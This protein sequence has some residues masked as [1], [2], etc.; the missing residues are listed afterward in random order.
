VSQQHPDNEDL[1]AMKAAYGHKDNTS[2]SGVSS[3]T[4]AANN[5]TTPSRWGTLTSSSADGKTQIYK[6]DLGDGSQLITTAYKK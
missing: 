4:N 3:N 1:T 2:S 6:L 5:R